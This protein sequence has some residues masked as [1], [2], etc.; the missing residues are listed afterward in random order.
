[1]WTK[2]T[3]CEVNACTYIHTL[4]GGNLS[5]C[6]NQSLPEEDE[7]VWDDGSAY[8]ETC[9]DQV[10]P[11]VGKVFSFLIIWLL[12]MMS[13]EHLGR[14]THYIIWNFIFIFGCHVNYIEFKRMLYLDIV[15]LFRYGILHA[16]LE[17]LEQ[18]TLCVANTCQSENVIF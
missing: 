10:A 12:K 3:I 8:P 4:L 5:T 9:L 1:M 6:L 2:K 16:R 15:F 17:S 13:F 18:D 14:A 7:L 11:M